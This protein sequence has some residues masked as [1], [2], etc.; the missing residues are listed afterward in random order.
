MEKSRSASRAISNQPLA[1]C[2]VETVHERGYNVSYVHV[3][4]QSPTHSPVHLD[5]RVE[6]LLDDFLPYL[7]ALPEEQFQS[8]RRVLAEKKTAAPS[9]LPRE[10]DGA[11]PGVAHGTHAFDRG[12]REAALLP[13]VAKD[14]AVAV[15]ARTLGRGPARRKLS[16]QLFSEAQDK[17]RGQAV[18]GGALSADAI[19]AWK[20]VQTVLV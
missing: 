9:S 8:E 10:A 5:A 4:I 1:H 6:A 15:A 11:W 12:A 7:T 13:S 3:L 2:K 20:A 14:F 16:L 17:A 18:D 19:P